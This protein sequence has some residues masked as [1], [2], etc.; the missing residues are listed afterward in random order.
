[1]ALK[2]LPQFVIKERER[3]NHVNGA[4]VIVTATVKMYGAVMIINKAVMNRSGAVDFV[5]MLTL[6][7][8]CE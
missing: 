3:K 7:P 6:H 5:K 8:V 2:I 4:D 1:M